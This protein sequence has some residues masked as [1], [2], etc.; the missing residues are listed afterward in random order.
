MQQ[1]WG[2]YHSRLP[3]HLNGRIMRVCNFV[4]IGS[5]D[6][7]AGARYSSSRVGD[8]KD[9]G[10]GVQTVRG[11]FEACHSVFGFAARARITP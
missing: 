8:E 4:D 3:V 1:Q 11:D 10:N 2:E 9:V 5:G 6:C 7:D